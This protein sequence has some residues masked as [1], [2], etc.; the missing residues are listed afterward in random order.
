MTENRMKPKLHKKIDGHRNDGKC[1]DE[2]T[3]SRTFLRLL[4]S[5]QLKPLDGKL[6]YLDLPSNGLTKTLERDIIHLGGTVE[7]FF[8]KEIKYLV[9][10]KR[11]AKYVGGIKHHSPVPSPEPGSPGT[12]PA[13]RCA[14][15][16]KS[17]TQAGASVA[18]R[19]KSL[20]ERVVKEKERLQMNKILVN[21]LEWG[22]K[23]LYVD[24]FIKYI[25]RKKKGIINQSSVAASRPSVKTGPAAN[26]S[27]HKCNGERI[28]KPFVKVEDTSRLYRP[29]YLTILK[30]PELNRDIAPPVTPVNKTK[31]SPG[32]RN[33][34]G[35]THAQ[36]KW[37]DR[38]RAG[39][40]ECCMTKYENLATH[41]QSERHKDFSKSDNYLV[42]DKLIS[43]MHCCF[44]DLRSD[45]KRSKCNIVPGLKQGAHVNTRKDRLADSCSQ[46][47]HGC[48]LGKKTVSLSDESHRQEDKWIIPCSLLMRRTYERKRQHTPVPTCTQRSIEINCQK[49]E[50]PPSGG[51]HHSSVPSGV[52]LVGSC[53]PS[54][55]PGITTSSLHNIKIG[56]CLADPEQSG[57]T[58]PKKTTGPGH[59]EREEDP[60]T[61]TSSPSP[62]I[63]R[64]VRPPKLRRKETPFVGHKHLRS[65]LDPIRR[66]WEIFQSS[67]DMDVEFM[68]FED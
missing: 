55:N 21:A 27:A 5:A 43:A 40:C 20:V 57:H 3:V 65:S 11:E 47:S 41:L 33:S 42:V 29:I 4:A 2:S 12:N 44:L 61:V 54:S 60:R 8:S 46:A 58:T 37:R 52:A 28:S 31:E 56:S 1:G 25:E 13:K 53:G 17:Q 22:V 45:V 9:T 63:V 15:S 7:K 38:N 34:E 36:R 64:K 39:W 62:K 19:G 10:N 68:G 18:S 26:P 49:G 24:D 23:I 14:D 51:E 48:S 67:D 59:S 32:N 30:M 6:I 16:V 50:I 35:K 66:L